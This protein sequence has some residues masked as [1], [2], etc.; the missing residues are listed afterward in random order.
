[1]FNS[2]QLIFFLWWSQAWRERE[3]EKN[4]FQVHNQDIYDQL[5][6]HDWL[7]KP[8]YFQHIFS[9]PFLLQTCAK[10]VKK[11]IFPDTL[12]PR[13]SFFVC[14]FQVLRIFFRRLQCTLGGYFWRIAKL[15]G[16]ICEFLQALAL[17]AVQH[18]EK[19][20]WHHRST[21]HQ[22]QELCPLLTSS[23][24]TSSWK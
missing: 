6:A 20:A 9:T 11:A 19:E 23:F 17:C 24:Q 14:K 10:F 5:S 4:S 16:I 7:G 22:S 13:I 3:R 2:I 18:Q 15:H 21:I 12:K 8:V 1:M